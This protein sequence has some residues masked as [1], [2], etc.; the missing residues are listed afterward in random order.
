MKLSM[1]VF[2]LALNE[3]SAQGGGNS[4]NSTDPLIGKSIASTVPG[5]FNKMKCCRD[6]NH[7]HD[8]GW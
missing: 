1:P 6:I 3:V 8:T 5:S 4:H 7:A 2:L